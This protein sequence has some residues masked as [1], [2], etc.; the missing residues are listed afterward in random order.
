MHRALRLL[1]EEQR[2][3]FLLYEE[4]GLAIDVIANITGANRET[5]KSRLRYAVA[6]LKTHLTTQELLQ[7]ITE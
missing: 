2:D 1:P 3:V 4:A 5:V 7:D 6:K